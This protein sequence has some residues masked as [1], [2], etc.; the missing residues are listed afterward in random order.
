MNENRAE[1]PAGFGVVFPRCTAC[2][3]PC[4]LAVL[5]SRVHASI[6]LTLPLQLNP[7]LSRDQEPPAQK[8]A[9]TKSITVTLSF[10]AYVVVV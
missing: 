8:F 5:D 9:K 7:T 3:S 10:L 4:L 2:R 6:F 1:L